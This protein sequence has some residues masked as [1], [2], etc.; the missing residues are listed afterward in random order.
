MWTGRRIN[1][2][3]H[4]YEL[5]IIIQ[6]VVF[7]TIIVMVFVGQK[8]NYVVTVLFSLKHLYHFKSLL[9]WAY[10][11]LEQSDC[12]H[13]HS[14]YSQTN[15]SLGRSSIHACPLESFHKTLTWCYHWKAIYI[16]V[17][18]A[19]GLRHVL[20]CQSRRLVRLVTSWVARRLPKTLQYLSYKFKQHTS[21]RCYQTQK[22]IIYSFCYF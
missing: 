18:V 6:T 1:Y 20:N 15:L 14:G 3:I 12:H 2:W 4:V 7:S 11:S 9:S 22:T 17:M 8:S 13:F 16:K 19:E 10:S 21:Q 5:T